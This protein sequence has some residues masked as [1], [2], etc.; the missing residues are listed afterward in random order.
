MQLDLTTL[1]KA[2]YTPPAAGST[3]TSPITRQEQLRQ[4]LKSRW[5]E[6]V[7]NLNQT[8]T[9]VFPTGLPELDQLL[10]LQGIPYGQLIEITGGVSSGKTSLL[11]RLMAGMSSANKRIAYVDFSRSFFPEAAQASGVNLARL[12]VVNAAGK[13]VPDGIRTGEILL[14]EHRAHVVAFDLV[15]AKHALPIGLLHRLRLRTVKSKGLVIFLTQDNSDIIPA[16]MASL[17]LT[18]ERLE[19]DSY[20]L[21]ITKSRICPEGTRLGVSL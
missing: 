2:P 14:R 10:P 19:D 9:L 12:V 13:A 1:Y 21:H 17:R 20:R 4:Q 6:A 15:S 8:Q 16:S 11:F 3:I 18:T 7:R 5:P